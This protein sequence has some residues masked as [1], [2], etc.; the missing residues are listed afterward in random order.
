MS[1][2]V[3]LTSKVFYVQVLKAL[4]IVFGIL[5]LYSFYLDF[6]TNHGEEITVPDLSGLTEE[7]VE[8]KLDDLD[9]DY[10]VLDTVDFRSG[11]EKY[12]VVEQNPAPGSKVKKDRK[13]YLKIN[14]GSFGFVKMPEL[15]Q[16]TRR[17]AE[18]NLTAMGLELGK[19]IYEPYFAKDIILELRCNGKIL[20][21]GDRV[22]KTSKI[23][24]VLG[25]GKDN[26]DEE[27]EVVDSIEVS[28]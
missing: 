7:A 8:E 12:T 27:Q 23:D 21:A 28:E 3:F 18:A 9:L 6:S 24:L 13:I 26:F 5:F 16:K 4:A 11:F 19:M 20:K 2:K 10:F 14:A 25:D 22:M 1:L 17:Q 15:I